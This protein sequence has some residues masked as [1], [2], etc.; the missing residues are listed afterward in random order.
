MPLD[1]ED[2]ASEFSENIATVQAIMRHCHKDEDLSVVRIQCTAGSK[3]GDNY[4]SLIKRIKAVIKSRDIGEYR[5]GIKK[6]KT[7]RSQKI[8]RQNSSRNVRRESQLSTRESRPHSGR[9]A[10]S[11]QFSLSKFDPK[12]NK[13]VASRAS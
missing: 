2:E 9:T 3:D 12:N 10:L 4:M 6:V 13:K 8:Q 7:V 5:Q 1:S 11:I